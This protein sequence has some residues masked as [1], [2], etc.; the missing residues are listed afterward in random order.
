[1]TENRVRVPRG[2]PAG[3]RFAAAAHDEPGDVLLAPA[4]TVRP[5]DP[6]GVYQVI[7]G[8]VGG[9]MVGQITYVV[10]DDL[11]GPVVSIDYISTAPAHRGRGVAAAMLTALAEEHP[12]ACFQ[13]CYFET[14]VARRVWDRALGDRSLMGAQY[15]CDQCGLDIDGATDRCRVCTRYLAAHAAGEHAEKPERRCWECNTP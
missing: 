6:D 1:M 15:R 7:E 10:D 9:R 11:D 8:C 5:G 2:V 3:G 14:P 13:T 12:D 4:P